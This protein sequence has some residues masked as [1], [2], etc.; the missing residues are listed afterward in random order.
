MRYTPENGMTR[1]LDRLAREFKVSTLVVLR[2]LHDAGY[3]TWNAYHRAFEAERARILPMLEE[4]RG[5]GGNFYNT[6]PMRVSKLFTRS[7][8]ASALEGQTLFTDAFQMLGFK[9]QATFG[10]LAQ[11]MG[12]L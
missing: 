2:R 6:Q 8:I 10:E 4:A 9:K 1:E 12:V 3:L 11:R 7:V 5:G